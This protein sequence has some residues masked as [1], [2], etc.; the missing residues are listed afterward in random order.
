MA[1]PM[2]WASFG[3]CI[4]TMLHDPKSSGYPTEPK[5]ESPARLGG[6]GQGGSMKS[7]RAYS[8]ILALSFLGKQNLTKKIGYSKIRL[9]KKKSTLWREYSF[10]FKI[11][12][13]VWILAYPN[14]YS[15]SP[16]Y[17]AIGTIFKAFGVI[18]IALNCVFVK[19][20]RM[21]DSLVR[22]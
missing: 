17:Q 20:F 7:S 6:V 1:R 16:T 19:S 11:Y 15:V 18:I 3:S 10:K 12:K 22:C 14:N 5:K 4:M 13:I 9:D 2:L 21:N 8:T